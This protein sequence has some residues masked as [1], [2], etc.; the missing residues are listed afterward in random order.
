MPPP[1]GCP[2]HTAPAARRTTSAWLPPP[3]RRSGCHREPPLPSAGNRGLPRSGIGCE[4]TGGGGGGRGA[5]G[6]GGTPGA[7]VPRSG[8]EQPA[9]A[10]TPL[11]RTEENL[12]ADLERAGGRRGGGGSIGDPQAAGAPRCLT[13]RS[14]PTI[15]SITT[16]TTTRRAARTRKS[17]SRGRRTGDRRA[18]PGPQG[19]GALLRE[20]AKTGLGAGGLTFIRTLGGSR[21]G[22]PDSPRKPQV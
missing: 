5:G 3:P 2:P 14:I 8:G 11:V 22:S 1:R 21:E 6:W 18:R 12:R 16:P 20:E 10:Q 7:Q 4:R 17:G 19:S 9:A 15:V 13:A